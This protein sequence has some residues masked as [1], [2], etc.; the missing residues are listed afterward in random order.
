MSRGINVEKAV[1]RIIGRPF[2][3][4]QYVTAE[5]KLAIASDLS[6]GIVAMQCP[7]LHAS[8]ETWISA[9]VKRECERIRSEPGRMR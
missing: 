8:L 4:G 5:E 2:R 6:I 1:G 3:D 7:H 9:R